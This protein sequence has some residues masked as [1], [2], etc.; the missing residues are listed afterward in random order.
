MVF[1]HS[2]HHIH[3][4]LWVSVNPCTIPDKNNKTFQDQLGG[5]YICLA[6]PEHELDNVLI[7]IVLCIVESCVPA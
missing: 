2:W 4:P 5:D 7:R 6:R 3:A 1:H